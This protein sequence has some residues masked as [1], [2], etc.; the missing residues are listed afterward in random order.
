VTDSSSLLVGGKP[1]PPP[2]SPLTAATAPSDATAAIAAAVKPALDWRK[3]LR[4]I[5]EFKYILIGTASTW[6]LMD[7]AL[8]SYCERTGRPISTPLFPPARD[9]L[10]F[11]VTFY[12]QSLMNTTVVNSAVVSTAGLN[13]ISKLRDSLLATIYIMC[14]AGQGAWPS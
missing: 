7:G 4:V 5:W 14:V 13:P 8:N 9:A 12:G 6:F 3:S 10:M 2:P 1:A 11:A